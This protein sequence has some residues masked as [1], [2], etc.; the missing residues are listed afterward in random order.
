MQSLK[1]ALD[2]EY[3]WPALYTFKFVVPNSRKQD[4]ANFFPQQLISWKE[5][6]TGKYSSLTCTQTMMSSEEVLA[7]YEE[8]KSHIP[9]AIGL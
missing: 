4:L 6:R 5:S 3:D 8:V 1:D 7:I 2:Q 9:E